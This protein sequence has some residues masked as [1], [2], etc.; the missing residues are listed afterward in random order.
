MGGAQRLLIGVYE[1]FYPT[2]TKRKNSNMDIKTIRATGV[3]VWSNFLLVIILSA[4][5]SYIIS[6]G[7]RIEV[8]VLSIVALVVSLLFSLDTHQAKV[9][10]RDDF[11]VYKSLFREK[12]IR[13]DEVSRVSGLDPRKYKLV[14]FSFRIWKKSDDRDYVFLTFDRKFGKN[15]YLIFEELCR[16]GYPCFYN[17][18][19]KVLSLEQLPNKSDWR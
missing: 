13:K 19:Q 10:I 14:P 6:L 15:V 5:V 16:F 1:P 11:I 17:D 7:V 9:T 18:T 8:L 12:I 4:F 3:A 2:T